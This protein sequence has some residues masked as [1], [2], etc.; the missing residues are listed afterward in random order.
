M[1]ILDPHG[2]PNTV[3][4][5]L[6]QIEEHVYRCEYEA[7]ETRVHS[8]NVFFAGKP[9]NKSPFGVRVAPPCDPRRVRPS[10]RGL[11]PTGVRIGDI[12][13]FRIFTDG[14]GE[15]EIEVKVIK[16]DEQLEKVNMK[17][18]SDI[19]YEC[20]YA[21]TVEGKHTVV[22]NFAGQE[23]F[24]SPYEVLVGPPSN[25]K[26]R[27]YGPGLKG[28]VEKFA[29]RFRVDTNGE[30]GTLGFTVEGPSE[31]K[32]ECKDNGD[33][34]V[35][36]MYHP[37]APGEY[38]IHVLTNGE[39]IPK[40]PWVVEIDPKPE[41]FFPEK[42][43]VSGAGVKESGVFKGKSTEFTVNTKEAGNAILEATIMDLAYNEV[44][45]NIK[46][47]KDGTYKCD[48]KPEKTGRHVVQVNFGGVGV[49]NAP[50]N[51]I[52][53]KPTDIKKVKI[54]GYGVSSQ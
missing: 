27:A 39:D 6:R 46:D 37:T 36:V 13:D 8:I 34:T 16:P 53:A 24:R 29:A 52:V 23:I 32:I 47:N 17:K 41:V 19:K 21:P 44:P 38:A 26:I 11:Q 15:G 10:G 35:N 1:V 20:E 2:K 25:S 45:V 33:G 51:V 30:V 40:S 14:A 9:I 28:G 3:P 31:A 18:I 43:Q 54:S 48:Y 50:Y 49:P 22:V 12:A 7:E 5:R 42:V 4:M